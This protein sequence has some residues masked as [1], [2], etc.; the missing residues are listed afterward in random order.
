MATILS[1]LCS[2]SDSAEKSYQ[3][4]AGG[5][6]LPLAMRQ[7][8]TKAFSHLGLARIPLMAGHTN[9]VKVGVQLVD[10]GRDLLREVAGIHVGR[11]C[12]ARCRGGMRKRSANLLPAAEKEGSES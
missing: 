6:F 12:P 3:A 10:D 2:V 11:P 7:S 5:Q 1:W 8:C 9:L 4:E